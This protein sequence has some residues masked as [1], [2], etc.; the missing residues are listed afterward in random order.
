MH[1]LPLTQKLLCTSHTH[2]MVSVLV[3]TGNV[4]QRVFLIF[5]WTPTPPGKPE[6]PQMFD[7][8]SPT[9][10]WYLDHT[11]ASEAF[12]LLADGKPA[13]GHTLLELENSLL[14]VA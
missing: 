7:E 10:R 1:A 12:A 2:T 11:A 6:R 8:N 9:Y 3:E 14:A 4:S 5:P 13:K